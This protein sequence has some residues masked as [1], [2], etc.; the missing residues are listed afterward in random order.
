MACSLSYL[1]AIASTCT[2]PIS[3]RNGA[4]GPWKLGCTCS[5]INVVTL[6]P[7]GKRLQS[8]VG[9]SSSSHQRLTNALVVR[10]ESGKENVAGAIDVKVTKSKNVADEKHRTEVSPFGLVDALLPKRTMRQMLDTMEGQALSVR[11]PWDI[12]ENENELKMRFDMPGL[13]KDD[14]KVSV[15]E[16]RVLV[17]EEREERQKDLWSFYSSYHTR[18]VLPE[19]YETNEIGA[20]LN[21][22]VLKITI[23]KTK[24]MSKI[25]DLPENR[26]M[27][28]ILA[29]FKNG[30]LNIIIPIG[31]V[32]SKVKDLSVN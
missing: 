19:N 31:K 18:L 21:N 26:E 16:D 23:P 6:F 24:V 1:P 22:G 15:V 27:D 10:A 29:E 11:T 3:A 28:K 30:V 12:I 17:I 14:V 8:N 2:T 25:N 20:E 13:S 7:V 5:S 9:W 32:V 4:S